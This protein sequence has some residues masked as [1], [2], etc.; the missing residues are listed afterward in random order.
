[1]NLLNKIRK[2]RNNKYHESIVKN[3]DNNLTYTIKINKGML[4]LELEV[5]DGKYFITNIFRK[6]IK[7]KINLYDQLIKVNNKNLDEMNLDQIIL[8][9]KSLKNKDKTIEILK[10]F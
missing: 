1:M 10:F 9:C 3:V 4:G 7:D 2:I 8:Y 6:E 5:S